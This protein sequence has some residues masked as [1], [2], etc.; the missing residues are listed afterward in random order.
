MIKKII[1]C[2]I[3]LF[4]FN[5]ST[6]ND[7]DYMFIIGKYKYL[8]LTLENVANA[9]IDLK[10]KFPE[11]VFRQTIK[12]SGW[13][14]EKITYVSGLAIY[15][16]NLFGMRKAKQRKNYALK[17][18]YAG[19]ATYERWI[20]SV[21]DYFE[22]QKSVLLKDNENYSSYLRRRG[23]AKDTKKYVNT[24]MCYLLPEN[25]IKIFKK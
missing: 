24:L 13:D 6:A 25:I 19:Y 11:Q 16:N 5:N 1:I 21:I 22:W 3:V 4:S 23:Y 18:T 15:G 12:E 7:E 8:P 9:I 2:I 17:K 10:I 20:F 14:R